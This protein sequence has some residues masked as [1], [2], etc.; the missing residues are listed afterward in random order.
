MHDWTS[1]YI[2][3]CDGGTFS[4]SL[5]EPVK[6][7]G[8]E[9]HFKGRYILEAV[10]RS[11]ANR[12]GEDFLYGTDFVI[13]GSSA[14]GLAVLLHLDWWREKLPATATVVGLADSGFFLDWT[15]NRTA[16][17]SFDED[18]RWGFSHMN[19]SDGVNHRCVASAKKS[20][21]HLSDCYFAEHT[22]PFIRTPIF[23]L[24]SAFDSWQ[25]QWEHGTGRKPYNFSLL[26]GYG[27]ELTSRMKASIGKCEA[28]VGG[29][30]EHCYH[31]CTTDT[32]WST[33]PV[34][35]GLTQQT[36]FS[37]WYNGIRTA[38]NTSSRMIGANNTV[39]WQSGELPCSS[40]GC[41]TGMS[42]PT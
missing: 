40:C 24:Q 16:A 9:V 25:L 15:E 18:L 21:R 29:F 14:G 35:Q 42:G 31:H 8:S 41:P 38:I 32:L 33:T 4:G 6:M 3:Y 17:H 20:G 2:R 12:F 10:V 13:G 36:A 34:I 22:L 27:A 30:V 1:I 7:N 28:A 39:L 5:D 26:N 23:L 37:R 11:L 19:A